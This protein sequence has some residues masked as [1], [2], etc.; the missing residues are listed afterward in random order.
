[1]DIAGL[2]LSI[3]GENIP[4]LN[5]YN[6]SITF[7]M[8]THL[9]YGTIVLRDEDSSSLQKFNF[10]IGSFVFATFIE[11]SGTLSGS[12]NSHVSWCPLVIT[13]IFHDNEI[14]PSELGG[15][16]TLAVS[17]PWELF[18]DYSPHAY[19]KQKISS[20]VQKIIKDDTRGM[21]FTVKDKFIGTTDDKGNCPRYKVNESDYDFILNK[22]LPYSSIAGDPVHFFV[23]ENGY[24]HFH[25]LKSMLTSSVLAL[26]TPSDTGSEKAGQQVRDQ[27]K[28]S[29]DIYLPFNKFYLSVGGG[30]QVNYIQSVKPKIYI[31]DLGTHKNFMIN[32]TATSFISKESG[33]N[34]GNKIPISI[35][36]IAGSPSTNSFAFLNRSADDQA[37]LSTN[38]VRNADKIFLMT[39]D[40]LFTGIEVPIGSCVNVF[41]PIERDPIVYKA[42][43]KSHWLCGKWVVYQA[44]HSM[45]K[46]SAP[47]QGMVTNL[48]LARPTFV[49]NSDSTSLS[50]PNQYWSI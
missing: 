9:P 7:S 43:A 39:V 1:M 45:V 10:A 36:A 3:N 31:E 47:E 8:E 13:K 49:I 44:T 4:T 42:N 25:S 11:S 41:V 24:A 17:H 30:S 14:A 35:G 28:N 27:A 37:G 26:V 38:A 22:L 46:P 2:R 12:D 20:L 15:F 6:F 48:V 19:G 29:G 50:N 32:K 5:I 33:K 40:T 18:R 34:S 23:D 21:A 16:L